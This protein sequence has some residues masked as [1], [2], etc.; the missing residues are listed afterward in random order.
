MTAELSALSK[1]QECGPIEMK[2]I[3][4]VRAYCFWWSGGIFCR[5]RFQIT[6]STLRQRKESS[7]VRWVQPRAHGWSHCIYIRIF[8][9]YQNLWGIRFVRRQIVQRWTFVRDPLWC[10]QTSLEDFCSG[11]FTSR[12]CYVSTGLLQVVRSFLRALQTP[13]VEHV[14]ISFIWYSVSNMIETPSNFSRT[15]FAKRFQHW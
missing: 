6:I 11:G 10:P 4:S 3:I 12:A 8:W 9:R 2:V 7:C 13:N 1:F 5:A 15:K 14:P